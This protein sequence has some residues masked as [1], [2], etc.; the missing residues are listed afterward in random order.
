ME[1][2]GFKKS[3]LACVHTFQHRLLGI[4]HPLLFVWERG[5]FSEGEFI[6]SLQGKLFCLEADNVRVEDS[7]ICSSSG[8]KIGMLS[9]T[10]S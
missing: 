7:C 4:S 6:I 5:I 1:A 3:L 9:L 10:Y 2:K 8:T